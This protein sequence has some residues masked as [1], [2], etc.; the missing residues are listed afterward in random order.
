MVE[1]IE[2]TK[3]GN[4]T[5]MKFQIVPKYLT[6]NIDE[7]NNS[8]SIAVRE[9]KIEIEKFKEELS[10]DLKGYNVFHCEDNPFVKIVSYS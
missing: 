2:I 9:L 10:A 3:K 6:E 7:Y 4:E 1:K 5:F 8:V